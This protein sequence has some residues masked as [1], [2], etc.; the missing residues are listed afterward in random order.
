MLLE[1]DLAIIHVFLIHVCH[2]I[3]GNYGG[4]RF[5]GRHFYCN[6]IYFQL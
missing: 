2:Y 5:L 3:T 1:F 4:N 6:N